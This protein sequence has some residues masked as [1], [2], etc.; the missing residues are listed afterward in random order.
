[1]EKHVFDM[2]LRELVAEMGSFAKKQGKCSEILA[3]NTHRSKNLAGSKESVQDSLHNLTIGVK[4]LLFDLEATK[5]EN[6]YLKKIIENSE[7]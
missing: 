5:R 7:S 3:R 1:M 4:Y 6:E 2:K